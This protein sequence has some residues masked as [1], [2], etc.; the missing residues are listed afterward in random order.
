[1]SLA[2][3]RSLG[4]HIPDLR[5]VSL[6][7]NCGA[8]DV[9]YKK[10]GFRF[11]VMAEI[12]HRR[13]QVALLNHQGAVGISGDLRVTWPEVVASYRNRHGDAAPT[14]LAA[15]PPCQGMSS[16]R[17]GKGRANDPD[18]GTRDKRN[19]LVTVI[20][21]VAEELRPLLVIVENV[22]AFLS[23]KV[24]HPDTGTP[25]S[26]AALLLSLLS[27]K[28]E[29]FPLLTNLCD[30][31]VPQNRVRSFIT[32]VRSDIEGLKRL[33]HYHRAPFPRPTSPPEYGGDGPI[34]ITQALEKHC[35]PGLDAK[36]EQTASALGY[37]GLHRVPIWPQERY[38][39]IAEIPPNSA[40]SAWQNDNCPSCGSTAIDP[41]R[42]T[43]P[44][45]SNLLLRPVVQEGDGF[46][47]VRGFR[48]SSYRRMHPDQPAATVT[49]ASGHIGSDYTLHPSENRVLSPLECAI[50]QTF[51][52][53]F[54]WGNTL[55]E[56]GH[57]H[58]RT[59]IGEA[60]P[61][62]FTRMHGEVL[63]GVLLDKWETAPI[64]TSDERCVKAR[65][66]LGSRSG[67]V[68]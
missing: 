48:T 46:R 25:V 65:R 19:L 41:E 52:A 62:R 44:M 20:A 56:Y 66:K 50:L 58:L 12:D 1:M 36:N 34:T 47:L 24:R 26:A 49:T 42:A 68:S 21:D 53:D 32:F 9:G 17:S 33:R 39:M 4:K 11:D 7:S 5:A 60:V 43:C 23:R 63:R 29:A 51:P 67:L 10:A 57:T 16:A 64:S 40:R 22:A 18:A 38:R 15:C 28:Y 54:N 3:E 13:L 8:G 27:T 61:P 35:L 55:E 6:F 59:M 30:F 37:D 45:C 2:N 14:L 31:G